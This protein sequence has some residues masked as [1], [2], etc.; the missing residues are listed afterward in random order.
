MVTQ[1]PDGQ[2]LIGRPGGDPRLVVAGGCS[3]HAFKHATGIGELVAQIVTGDDTL[4]D[5]AFV[6]PNR[7]LREEKSLAS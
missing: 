4:I 6:D 5:T 3:G 7:F 2:F 1:T